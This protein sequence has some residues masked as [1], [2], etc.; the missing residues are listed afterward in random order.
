ML[1]LYEIPGRGLAKYDPN[2]PLLPK[3]AVKVKPKQKP[4]AKAAKPA[5]KAVK[6]ENK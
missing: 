1:E 3:G 6:A 4:K 5:N 2:D